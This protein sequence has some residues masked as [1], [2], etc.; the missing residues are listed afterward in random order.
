MVNYSNGKIYKIEPNCDHDEAEIY[1]GSTTKQYLSQRMDTHRKHYKAYKAGKRHKTTSFIL[2][3]KYG[4]ENCKIVLLEAVNAESKDELH[5]REAHY[6]KT[7]KCV[8]KCVPLRSNKEYYEDNK[9]SKI[10]QYRQTNREYILKYKHAYREANREKLNQLAKE[11]Y[12]QNKE[13][14]NNRQRQ[15]RLEAK[16]KQANVVS[17]PKKS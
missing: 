16:A 3:D 6:I 2:F 14:I 1:I 9:E 5:A 4:I 11:Y 7:L 13:T 15:K 8:N 10:K 12:E 17:N